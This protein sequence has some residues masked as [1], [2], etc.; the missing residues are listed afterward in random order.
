MFDA[1]ADLLDGT[2]DASLAHD[3][4]SDRGLAWR[5]WVKEPTDLV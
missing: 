4:A 2:G 1:I 3:A 5:A